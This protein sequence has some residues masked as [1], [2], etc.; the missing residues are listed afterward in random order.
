M[1]VIT[2]STSATTCALAKLGLANLP[3]SDFQACGPILKCGNAP[4]HRHVGKL[5]IAFLVEEGRHSSQHGTPRRGAA[6]LVTIAKAGAPLQ[7]CL[8]FGC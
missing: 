1:V 4:S 6:M 2:N 3:C 7:G 8:C 5:Q